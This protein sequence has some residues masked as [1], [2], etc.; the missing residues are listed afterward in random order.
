MWPGQLQTI[1]WRW[2]SKN[3][4]NKGLRI[5]IDLKKFKLGLRGVVSARRIQG[6]A[7]QVTQI[8][9]KEKAL[10]LHQKMGE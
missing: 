2:N 4:D 3:L 1:G 9:L 10:A 7:K 6:H 8:K 5:Y